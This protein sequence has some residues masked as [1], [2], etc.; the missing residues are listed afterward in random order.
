MVDTDSLSLINNNGRVWD[1]GEV[2][3]DK[4]QTV[5]AGNELKP[6]TKYY[7]CVR[8]C[9]KEGERYQSAVSSFETAMMNISDWNGAWIS[10]GQSKEYH[11]APY[12][13]KEFSIGKKI[14]S[15]RAYIAVG[16][17]YELSL[18]GE[19][20]GN[21]RLDP[22][23]TRFDRRILYVTYDVSDYINQ[24]DNAI[25]VVLGNGWYNHQALGVWNF[26]NAPWR[27]RPT[28]C[29]DL[30]ITYD[31]NSTEI[32]S[33][34]LTWKTSGG[35]ITRNNIYTGENQDANKACLL[36]TSPSPRDRG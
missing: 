21:H 20:V 12:F 28:F 18:N 5:Y 24:G 16:G 19:K 4:M 1:T 33:S 27:N 35:K 34:N 2:T 10:D 14:K 7:W 11:P 26:N 3:S 31:D 22:M 36:Y 9:N 8:I 15:A 23:F 29:L 32:I 25:G 6:F 17:L 13:R 30:R